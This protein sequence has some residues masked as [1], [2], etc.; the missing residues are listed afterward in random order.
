[1]KA[2]SS[3][4]GS[5]AHRWLVC[6]AAPGACADIPSKTTEYAA[7]GNAA[8]A[9]GAKCLIE[10]LV[11]AQFIGTTV[12]TETGDIEVTEEMA[13]AIQIYLDT[14]REIKATLKG[15][16]MLV[17]HRFDITKA[18]LG[19]E[20]VPE[21]QRMFGTVD[22]AIIQPFGKVVVVDYKHGVG[23]KVDAEENEQTMYYGVGALTHPKAVGAEEVELVIVQ[24]RSF[25]PPV[26][27]W[28][29]TPERLLQDFTTLARQKAEESR[30]SPRFVVGSHCRMC[31]A[32]DCGSCQAL[33]KQAAEV[34][35]VQIDPAEQSLPSLLAPCFL[36]GEQ[37]ARVLQFAEILGPWLKAVK[38]H[39]KDRVRAGTG[40][41]GWKLVEGRASRKWADEK[42]V[43][44][45][46][47]PDVIYERTMR[48]PAQV[49][50]E[51]KA[52]K[53]DPKQIA[54]LTS[55][56]R[57]V[58]LVPSDDPRPAL[59]LNPGFTPISNA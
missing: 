41:P 38:E 46:L 53:L 55:T 34:A 47:P 9:I 15:S 22:C 43:V 11:A 14:V 10:D 21:W 12:T 25:G 16:I 20:D 35:L 7:E 44:D 33:R 24:P 17:E 19:T 40:V 13:E 58:S 37:V 48:S 18:I 1:M 49:E 32:G 5:G 3:L 26:K 2:H 28:D 29:T 51:L 59:N 56:S 4:G 6:T 50:K 45:T 27:R 31:P 36:T 23:I 30:T 57:G 42:L 52:R 54:P 39:A 8:H